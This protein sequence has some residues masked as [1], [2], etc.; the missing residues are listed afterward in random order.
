MDNT[1]LLQQ[2]IEIA[3]KAHA[4][5]IDKV[6]Q[7]YIMHPLRVMNM[8][9][10]IEEKIVGVLH[11]VIEDSDITFDDL[12]AEGFPEEIIDA[13][14]CVTKLSDDEPYDAFIE[15]VKQNPLAIK[16]KINDLTDNMDL[17]RLP[18]LTEKD[19]ERL[20]KYV[21]AYNELKCEL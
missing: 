5:Q 11:D 16:V 4:G 7:P 13:L 18:Y 2:A 3:V 19:F 14:W 12:S 15:R 17:K 6:G 9:N 21:S 10:T 20:Q 1:E 8:G